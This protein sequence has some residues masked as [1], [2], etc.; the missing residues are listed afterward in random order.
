[1]SADPT[2]YGVH[3]RACGHLMALANNG[4]LASTLDRFTAADVPWRVSV[5]PDE[6]AIAG[7]IRGERCA[8]CRHGE[9]E[10]IDSPEER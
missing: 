8:H 5:A 10:P 4:M 2:L 3:H 7:L 9:P 6:D 1:M